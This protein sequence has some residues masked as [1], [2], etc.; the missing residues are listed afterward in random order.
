LGLAP[1][2]PIISMIKGGPADKAGLRAF[3]RISQG[4][5]VVGDVVI[6]IS[7]FDIRTLDDLYAALEKY[8]PGDLVEVRVRRV[9]EVMKLKIRLAQGD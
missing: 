2:V 1:G 8:L 7:Q 9:D 6:G 5:I 3:R 4:R